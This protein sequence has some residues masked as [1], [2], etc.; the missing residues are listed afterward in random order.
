MGCM[1]QMKFVCFLVLLFTSTPFILIVNKTDLRRYSPKALW[2]YAK[3]TTRELA[4]STARVGNEL[5][6]S[7]NHTV[8][9]IKKSA[10]RSYWHDPIGADTQVWDDDQTL[11][12]I[13]SYARRF[14]PDHFTSMELRGH[15]KPKEMVFCGPNHDRKCLLEGRN[16]IVPHRTCAV[17]GNGGVLSGSLC[18]DDID[19]HDY[20]I[21]FS[22]AP[23]TGYERDVG[24]K[25]SLIF[26]NK[27]IVERV[28][29]S[30]TLNTSMN[31][32][33]SRLKRLDGSIFVFPM[34]KR[35]ELF[36]FFF[37][38]VRSNWITV[39]LKYFY[40]LNDV[41]KIM[42]KIFPDISRHI[43]RLVTTG[44][45]AVVMATNICDDIT[46]YGFY[47]Y[48]SNYAVTYE[49]LHYHYYPDDYI[50]PAIM[51]SIHNF[52]TEYRLLKEME[53]RGVLK[54]V[55]SRCKRPQT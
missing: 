42:S 34:G 45:T 26:M 17:V 30:L 54:L 14:R 52:T 23:I 8:H 29:K 43:G 21:R 50:E 40:P 10:R 31:V 5:G 9:I 53:K 25:T 55:T 11:D 28:Q 3:K 15:K 41:K 24:S 47:P 38:A 35:E 51:D 27:Q 33:R 44:L 48:K 32:Y 22:L 39:T 36:R 19:S 7:S 1:H 2:N 46:L 12:R 18:G 4:D 37:N 16:E 13:R 20:V 49:T 6:H